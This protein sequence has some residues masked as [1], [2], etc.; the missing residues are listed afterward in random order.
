MKLKPSQ[1]SLE[2]VLPNQLPR[3]VVG[4]YPKFVEFLQAYYRF[5]D[6]YS[7]DTYLENCRDI[8]LAQPMFI[9]LI[10]KEINYAGFKQ[11]NKERFF[12]A[13]FK[14]TV[15]N[16]SELFTITTL[17][18]SNDI[19]IK[20]NITQA[21]N[22]TTTLTFASVPSAIAVGQYV[23]SGG[24][25]PTGVTVASKTATTVTLSQAVTLT[26][27]V[28]VTFLDSYMAQGYASNVLARVATNQSAT[29]TDSAKS[30][31]LTLESERLLLKNIKSLLDAKGTTQA[32]KFLFRVMFNS[33]V[34]LYEPWVDVFAPSTGKYK[35]QIAVLTPFIYRANGVEYEGSDFDVTGAY[36][37]DANG[38][39]L[40]DFPIVQIEHNYSIK[41][42]EFYADAKAVK[43]QDYTTCVLVLP[44]MKLELELTATLHPEVQILESGQ[45]FFDKQMIKLDVDKGK[46]CLLQVNT[47]ANGKVQDATIK[48]YGV[49]YSDLT[50]NVDHYG[51]VNKVID[52][53]Q[54]IPF[55]ERLESLTEVG[56]VYKSEFFGNGVPINAAVGPG[57]VFP[58]VAGQQATASATAVL[59]STAV[60]L[61][62]ADAFI[63][64]GMPVVGTGI[65]AGT[66]VSA[67]IGTALTL[68]LPTSAAITASPITITVANLNTIVAT[69][70]LAAVKVGMVV[71]HTNVPVGT[72]VTALNGTTATMSAA[73][74]TVIPNG[75]IVSFIGSEF[76]VSSTAG[77]SVG[78]TVC[79]PT[80]FNANYNA[81]WYGS[82]ITGNDS[83]FNS[84]TGN[85]RTYTCTIAAAANVMTVT[86]T[87]VNPYVMLTVTGLTP[88][89][90]YQFVV[91]LGSVYAGG[92]ALC[93][94][95]NHANA[96]WNPN[97]A[98]KGLAVGA[99]YINFTSNTDTVQLAIAG[100]AVIGNTMT[101][102]SAYVYKLIGTGTITAVTSGTTFTIDNISA[103][104]NIPIN[105]MLAISGNEF[106]D[107][108]F[109]G[110][111]QTR[112]SGY[113][114]QPIRDV[115]LKVKVK[116]THFYAVGSRFD[117][118]GGAPSS[119]KRLQDGFYVQPYSYVVRSPLERDAFEPIVHKLLHPAGTLMFNE[120]SLLNELDVSATLG[121]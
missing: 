12:N 119:N 34:E 13:E 95:G 108:T 79:W 114:N 27:G 104:P 109:E 96:I 81:P 50:L 71:N 94:I 10:K 92:A 31:G 111:L 45:G 33:E 62:A 61:A 17:N 93:Y 36:L 30:F 115:P 113:L 74:T 58:Y 29:S 2:A 60:T 87:N 19:L 121:S 43:L 26:S 64:V 78:Q 35:N 66:T 83:T 56:A 48:S 37:A 21:A 107:S 47:D 11:S 5:L 88:N 1:V 112:F 110:T 7:I 38:K 118:L 120:N 40:Q 86:A 72:K 69:V 18:Y 116:K 8:D 70:A 85:W 9:E 6:E 68:S 42:L 51:E 82:V 101:V 39:K 106:V 25:I 44:A 75:Q 63:A 99:N 65:Q 80:L 4:Q 73:A 55:A 15:K 100:T 28:E 90:P 89:V 84:G 20:L 98:I 105:T 3:F 41:Y 22:N 16:I 32:F 49:G 76:T 91:T 67:I 59:N 77:L 46:Y 24:S 57:G 97:I 103:Y 53:H 14:D 54:T 52:P 117:S 102:T 23:F